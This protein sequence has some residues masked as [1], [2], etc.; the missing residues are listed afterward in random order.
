MFYNKLKAPV[1]Q[2]HLKKYI[3]VQQLFWIGGLEKRNRGKSTHGKRLKLI[4]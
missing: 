2:A 3:L 4:Y 1:E